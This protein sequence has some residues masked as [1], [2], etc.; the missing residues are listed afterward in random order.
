MSKEKIPVIRDRKEIRRANRSRKLLFLLFLFFITILII[1]FF[2]STLSKVT[3]IEIK[4]YNYV[5]EADIRAVLDVKLEDQFFLVQTKGIMEDVR[6]LEPIESVHITKVFPGKIIIEVLE[7]PAVALEY[8]SDGTTKV[9]LANGV[10]VPPNGEVPHNLPI[11]TGWAKDDPVKLALGV[12]LDKIPSQHLADVSEIIPIP[13][14]SYPDKVKIYT[15]SKYEVITSV[16][17]MQEMMPMLDNIILK[18]RAQE[19]GPGTITL[20]ETMTYSSFD[21]EGEETE[22]DEDSIM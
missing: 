10:A 21:E 9:L 6:Q 18:L 19:Q 17:Y 5:G 16:E 15:R 11:I 20:L 4:G 7:Y 2:N 12:A 1:L 14:V 22:I 13:T 8:E 3:E